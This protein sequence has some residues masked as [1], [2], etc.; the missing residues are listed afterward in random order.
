EESLDEL[1]SLARVLAKDPDQVVGEPEDAGLLRDLTERAVMHRGDRAHQVARDGE[2]EE[3]CTDLLFHA[4]GLLRVELSLVGV[5][6]IEGL[7]ELLH[8]PRQ[9]VEPTQRGPRPLA[10]RERGHEARRAVVALEPG[11]SKLYPAA[12]ATV[13]AGQ[14]EMGDGVLA[15]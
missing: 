9:T 14:V 7:V 15:S 6:G 10:F 12:L 5:V 11:G 8:L 4:S 2:E 3:A 1:H 13:G